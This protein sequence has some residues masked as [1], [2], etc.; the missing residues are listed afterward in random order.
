MLSPF[1][2]SCA[3]NVI[4]A[5]KVSRVYLRCV[6]TMVHYSTM[7]RNVC[8]GGGEGEGDFKRTLSRIAWWI[9]EGQ[10][11]SKVTFGLW[12]WCRCRS[13]ARDGFVI[14]EF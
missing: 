5:F 14:E 3:F 11:R 10:V 6:S 12:L 1:D 13:S 7:D 4:G 8:N 9:A 2:C